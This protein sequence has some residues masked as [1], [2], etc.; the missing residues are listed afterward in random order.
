MHLEG[1]CYC[2]AV[3]FKADGDPVLKAQCLCHE[4][5]HVTGGGPNLFIAMPPD[6]FAYTKGAPAS[7]KRPDLPNPVTREFCANCGT[8]LVTRAPGFPAAIVKAGTLDDR[9]LYGEPD[10]TIFTCDKEA[11]HYLPQGKP[12]FERLP[13]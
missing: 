4:C 3:R 9:S 5:T 8:Q 7:F 10:M 11:F 13:G 2:G 6:G 12:A 1:G